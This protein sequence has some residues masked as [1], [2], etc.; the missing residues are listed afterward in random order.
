MTALFRKLA[1][2]RTR[3]KITIL[4]L[5]LLVTAV[6]LNIAWSSH[7]QLRQA[8]SEMLEKTQILN[9]E[10]RAVWDFIDINQ[11]RIDTDADGNFNF[12]N[13]YCA[14]AGKSVAA[15]FM[16][17]N[18]YVIRYISL[19]PRKVNSEPDAFERQALERF[20]AMVG[21]QSGSRSSMPSRPTR[22]LQSQL[23]GRAGSFATPRRST[24]SSPALA[25]MADRKGSWM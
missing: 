11:R 10:M 22:I 1:D 9:Q 25:A 21:P 6:S 13:I 24:S 19:S 7:T 8:E 12:K 23:P 15:L 3:L 4:L 17:D 14:I 18:D 2:I 16:R 20:P 5:A